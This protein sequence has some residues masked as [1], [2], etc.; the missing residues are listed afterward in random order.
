MR[1]KEYVTDLSMGGF[2][3]SLNFPTGNRIS[4]NILKTQ[5]YTHVCI[6]IS[7]FKHTRTHVS[8]GPETLTQPLLKAC[9][10][11]KVPGRGKVKISFLLP[12]EV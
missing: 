3:M 12:N 9:F 7:V 1:S 8:P 11:E 10:H 2:F 5:T 4:E 6:Y